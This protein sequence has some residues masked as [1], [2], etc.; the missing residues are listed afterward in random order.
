ML[1]NAQLRKNREGKLKEAC[2]KL[3]Q[4]QQEG[5][6]VNVKKTA[7]HYGVPESTLC[8]RFSGAHKP[9]SAAH[10]HQQV[11]SA[12]QE[13]V[14]VE[15]IKHLDAAGNPISKRTIAQK[16]FVLSG[17]IPGR[18]WIYRFLRRNPSIKLGRP[19][20]LDPK[21]AQCF[22][23]ATV[24]LHFDMLKKII[25]MRGIPWE[26]IYNMDEKGCQRGGGRGHSRLKYL[27]SHSQRVHYKFKSDNFELVT[28]IECICA[29][30][31][32]LLPV[33]VFAGKEQSPSWWSIDP[34]IWYVMS[35]LITAYN[36]SDATKQYLLNS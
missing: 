19:S 23:R 18:N 10:E 3:R 28:I 9:P 7:A 27:M 35:S 20:G 15:W 36:T 6:E 33:F 24:T 29:D 25:N 26:N 16:C 17:H 12:Q 22:N 31:T 11:L 32:N 2:A 14:L 1:S 21:R 13:Q 34:Q 8:D 5:H 30:G 4:N